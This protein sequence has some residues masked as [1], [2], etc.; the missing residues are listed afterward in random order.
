MRT[1][2]CSKI[3]TL[4]NGCHVPERHCQC[5]P[6]EEINVEA[7]ADHFVDEIIQDVTTPDLMHPQAKF[8][9]EDALEVLCDE[10]L[11]EPFNPT[12]IERMFRYDENKA[13]E[14]LD[15]I[16]WDR[17]SQAHA[18]ELKK[19]AERIANRGWFDKQMSCLA[20]YA[21]IHQCH[22]K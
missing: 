10:K 14:V 19:E 2:D 6:V 22:A 4:C 12:H 5:V 3:V 8:T 17:L 20:F 21:M 11:G 16:Y 1:N 13:N 7:E 9:K 15:A 18:S